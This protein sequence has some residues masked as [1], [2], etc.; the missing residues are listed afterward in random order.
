MCGGVGGTAAEDRLIRPTDGWSTAGRVHA[1]DDSCQD[2]SGA[3]AFFGYG[4]PVPHG[5]NT[6]FAQD[7]TELVMLLQDTD[8]A[9]YLLLNHDKPG[10][11]DGGRTNVIIESPSLAV[12]SQV[13]LQR[14]PGTLVSS[15]GGCISLTHQCICRH[16]AHRY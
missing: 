8:G 5:S 11:P 16:W 2:V 12:R 4:F 6:G 15:A 10:N 3:E 9:G 14:V 7:D 1:G 13:S